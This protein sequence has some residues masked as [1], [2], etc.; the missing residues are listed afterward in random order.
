MIH[1][2]RKNVKFETPQKVGCFSENHHIKQDQTCL[3]K[4]LCQFKE[5]DSRMSY[6]KLDAINIKHHYIT[7]TYTT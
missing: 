5:S 2:L 3:Q 7:P 6:L 4:L 1:H